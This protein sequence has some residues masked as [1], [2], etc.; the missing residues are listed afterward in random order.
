MRLVQTTLLTLGLMT[1]YTLAASSSVSKE[2]LVSP[3]EAKEFGGEVGF[4]ELPA[5][6]LR[7]AVP[8][9]DI[10]KPEQAD[11]LKVKIPF[12]IIVQFKAQADAPIDPT[13]FKVMYGTFKFDI[14]GRV[15]KLV[16][17][18][19]DGFSIEAA[20]IPPGRHRLILHVQDEKMRVAER[21]LRLEVVE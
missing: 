20:E 1:C 21:E 15:T 14:T 3:T 19:K 6:R 9:I 7:G 5:L 17:V 16:K 12:P 13:T 2:W 4:N 8:M 10:I 11:G 18:T